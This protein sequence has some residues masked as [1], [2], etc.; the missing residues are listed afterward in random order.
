MEDSYFAVI[1]SIEGD[2]KTN[3][4]VHPIFL[5]RASQLRPVWV[6]S[7]KFQEGGRK[8]DVEQPGFR[9]S[10]LDAVRPRRLES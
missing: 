2:V 7:P 3:F 8:H 10:H 9:A 4:S 1:P 6:R 5:R